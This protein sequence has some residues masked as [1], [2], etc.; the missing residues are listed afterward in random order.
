MAIN[1]THTGFPC[2]ADLAFYHACRT[3]RWARDIKTSL[4]ADIDHVVNAH[5]GAR[6][7]SGQCASNNL[8]AILAGYQRRGKDLSRELVKIA[9]HPECA[10][11]PEKRAAFARKW[12]ARIGLNPPPHVAY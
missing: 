11:N 9:Q 6:T 8:M 10:I 2:S 4:I 7:T 5:A 12:A 1:K 3:P